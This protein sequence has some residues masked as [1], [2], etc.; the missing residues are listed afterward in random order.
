MRAQFGSGFRGAIL[1]AISSSLLVIA[2]L[3]LGD[4]LWAQTPQADE[5]LPG[6]KANTAFEIGSVDNVNL[7]TGDPG[8]VIPLGPAYPL[9]PGSTF[10][11]QAYYSAKFWHFGTEECPVDPTV[12]Y[13]YI[14]GYPTLGAGWTLELGY[15][16]TPADGSL[17]NGYYHSPDGGRHPFAGSGT[18]FYSVD[19]THLRVTSHLTDSP[20]NWLV[21][22]PDGSVQK[23]A[24]RYTNPRAAAGGAQNS[25]KA[26]DFSDGSTGTRFGLTNITDSFGNVVLAVTY[27][28]ASLTTD[29]WK[30]STISFGGQTISYSW[31]TYQPLTNGP[32]WP[33]LDFITFPPAAGHTLTA[34]FSFSPGN[35]ARNSY[36]TSWTGGTPVQCVWAWP[37]VNVP[38]LGS[39]SLKESTTV[40]SSWAFQY[41]PTP[42]P[43]EDPSYRDGALTQITLP[44]NGT[45]QYV[46]AATAG[47]CVWGGGGTACNDPETGVLSTGPTSPTAGG[48][49]YL[50]YLD[51][52]AAV[53]QR[54]ET[55][56]FT[57][58][59]SVTSY[60]RN[61][62]IPTVYVGP[63]W[64]P[65]PYHVARAVVAS[66]P[67]GNGATIATRHVFHVDV[68]GDDVLASG[69]EIE[70]R[71]YSGSDATVT[72][73]RT[74]IFCHQSDPASG[75]TPADPTCG[76][77]DSLGDIS[78]FAGTGENTRRQA[79]VTWYGVNPMVAGQS[80][81]GSCPGPTGSSACSQSYSVPATY[82]DVAGKYERTETTTN[83]QSMA[84]WSKRTTTTVWTPSVSSSEWMLNLF[85]SRTVSDTI[86]AS[87]TPVPVPT[88]VT[89]TYNF[90]T[91]NGFLNSMTT[92]DA[93][94]G[95]LTRTFSAMDSA[96]NPT[97]EDASGSGSGLAATTFTDTRA[98]QDGLVTSRARGGLTWFNVTRDGATGAITQSFDPNPAP[99]QLRTDYT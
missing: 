11:L 23:F 21:E 49:P 2:L 32:I 58:L 28:G 39:I 74:L 29:A 66:R 46:Y 76:F 20:P 10:Q 63:G 65:D 1:R 22:F 17:Y 42:V 37:S 15:V 62:V 96:G 7:F 3:P 64:V 16:N 52:S 91:T 79:T 24:Q 98:F 40:L 85:G 6:F 18:T 80:W 33:V 87:P 30:V 92:T 47:F 59:T 82:D 77:R 89:T 70:R 81:G 4:Q 83:L 35:I 12:K 60:T 78:G 56:P 43:A 72:P 97:R 99:H 34:Q 55:D 50:P 69:T 41:F 84:G 5:T 51:K 36:D 54:T 93:T 19:G 31:R 27:V 61:T 48:S 71:Y 94:Q 86:A 44:T 26:P 38:L 95:T 25:D 88:S 73:V 53:Q 45:I 8:V 67:N 57:G 9:G 13:A 75:G 14:N 90:D 68:L